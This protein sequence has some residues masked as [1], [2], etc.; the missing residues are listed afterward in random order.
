MI[1][2][3]EESVP[4]SKED[5]QR[6]KQEIETLQ[7]KKQFIINNPAVLGKIIMLLKL[8]KYK[9]NIFYSFKTNRYNK[10]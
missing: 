2:A 5:A 6:I 4:R 10:R 9:S 1:A 3:L 8:K 7:S